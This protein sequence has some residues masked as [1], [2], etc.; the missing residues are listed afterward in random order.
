MSTEQER[1][2][3]A[4][5]RCNNVMMKFFDQ[6]LKVPA[7]Q[8]N[9]LTTAHRYSATTQAMVQ[10][11][12]GRDETVRT[13]SEEMIVYFRCY[14]DYYNI[15]IRSE[16]YLGK[17]LSKDNNGLLGAFPAAGGKT[18][19]FNLLNNEKQIIT[20]D[21]LANNQA[22]VYLKAR[23]AGVIKRQLMQQPKLYSYG[24]Q[25]GD[26]LAFN[27]TILERNVPYPTSGEPYP[28]FIEPR[29]QSDDD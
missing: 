7:D 27:L 10:V 15:Q 18:T 4:S 8:G 28:L 23:N 1:S 21:N 9:L 26:S 17:Y 19:S 6:M 5:I 12:R 14:D 25:S 20:L 3:I 11:H 16:A 2:F 13:R 29:P 22:T 24:D